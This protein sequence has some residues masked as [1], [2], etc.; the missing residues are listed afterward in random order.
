MHQQVGKPPAQTLAASRNIGAI[1]PGGSSLIQQNVI[2]QNLAVAAA[3]VLC[4]ILNSKD[5]FS[6]MVHRKGRFAVLKSAAA[7]LP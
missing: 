1:Q 3:T 7:L 2:W 5:L 6:F 4:T